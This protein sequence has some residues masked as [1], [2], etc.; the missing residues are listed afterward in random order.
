MASGTAVF[1]GNSQYQLEVTANIKRQEGGRTYMDVVQGVRR[2]SGTGAGLSGSGDSGI[3]DGYHGDNIIESY[4]LTSSNYSPIRTWEDFFFVDMYY[5]PGTNGDLYVSFTD[6][7]DPSGLGAASVHLVVPVPLLSKATYPVLPT[8]VNAGSAM[9]ISLTPQDS[10]Y[11][12]D[13]TYSF[14]TISN[15]P[16]ATGVA[17]STSWTV[18]MSLLNEIPNAQTG[19]LT[20]TAVTRDSTGKSLGSQNSTVTVTVPTSA[21]PSVP[22]FTFSD[23]AG[24][25]GAPATWLQNV[26]IFKVDAINATA[27]YGATIVQKRVILEG[28]NLSVG[29]TRKLTNSG[30]IPYT[31]RV[32]DSRGKTRSV[33]GNLTVTGYFTPVLQEMTIFRATSG[34]VAQEDGVYLR[35]TLKV[36]RSAINPGTGDTNSLTLIL[37]TRPRGG[38]S[39]TTR[40]TINYA[41]TTLYNSTVTIGGGGIY[42]NTASYDV[43]LIIRD[44][45]Y[46]TVGV[47]GIADRVVPTGLVSISVDGTNVGI[48][49]QWAQGKLDVA[50]TIYSTGLNAGSGNVVAGGLVRGGTL[51]SLG[52]IS[53]AGEL[54]AGGVPWARLTGSLIEVTAEISASEPPGSYRQGCT[55]HSVGSAG[56]GWPTSLGVVV[57]DRHSGFRQTQSFYA[58]GASSR[59]WTRMANGDSAWEAW[60]EAYG[61]NTPQVAWATAAG[62]VVAAATWTTVT[63]PAGRFTQPP[64]V[65]GSVN[66]GASADLG[67]AAMITNVTSTQFIMRPSAGTTD[68]AMFWSAFQ[69]TSG[70]A[71]G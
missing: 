20:V 59:S 56:L 9:T 23:T 63:F 48:G 41:T 38:S 24:Y 45:S 25:A 32:W 29:S 47:Q 33:S 10:T 58:R 64:I 44:Q 26:S 54:T 46:T 30:S 1:S 14:G 7:L 68:V 21:Q 31:V 50:G 69:M 67:K 40:N 19:T 51:Q 49:K 6:V 2:I 18:P 12:H 34:G 55:I 60:T 53:W 27:Q 61:Q 16:I 71:S 11:R 43:R 42:S 5:P 39:W 57:T 8:S 35:A 15:A 4:D 36:L 62:S 52:D 66:S 13:L 28:A 65:L 22:T 17:T 70:S 3:G 37:Q